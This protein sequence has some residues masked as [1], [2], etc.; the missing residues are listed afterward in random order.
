VDITEGAGRAYLKAL[1]KALADR[2]LG[3]GPGVKGEVVSAQ[4][5]V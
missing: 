3:R 5:P 1:N 4:D 2:S